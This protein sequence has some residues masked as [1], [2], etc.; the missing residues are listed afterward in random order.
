M[1]RLIGTNW[2]VA[3][4]SAWIG[5]I[6][7]SERLAPGRRSSPEVGVDRLGLRDV[8]SS[9]GIHRRNRRAITGTLEVEQWPISLQC[10]EFFC[11]P[12]RR[13]LL[14]CWLFLGCTSRE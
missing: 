7:R 6:D 11:G 2:L 13:K 8:I 5:Q 10:T 12:R 4:F 1:R 14:L 9:K 3:L